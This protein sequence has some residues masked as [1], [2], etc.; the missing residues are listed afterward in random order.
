M[1]YAVNASSLLRGEMMDGWLGWFRTVGVV[2][3]V[4][5]AASRRS[6]G[7]TVCVMLD[8]GLGGRKGN[9]ICSERQFTATREDDG[10]VV[11]M[12]SD[13]GGWSGA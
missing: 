12:V 6:D 10:R 9:D 1:I 5:P 4:K 7:G 3:R 11:G 13:R 8:N 2:G